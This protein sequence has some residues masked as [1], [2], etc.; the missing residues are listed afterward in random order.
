MSGLP[1]STS[2]TLGRGVPAAAPGSQVEPARESPGE[3]LALGLI[4]IWLLLATMLPG[5]IALS[6]GLI[7]ED[8]FYG[9]MVI[10]GIIS[11]MVLLPLGLHLANAAGERRREITDERLSHFASRLVELY[12]ESRLSPQVAEDPRATQAFKLYALAGEE[13]R[14]NPR[15]PGQETWGMISRGTSLAERALEQ[16]VLEQ[17]ALENRSGE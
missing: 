3:I 14:Q 13:L 15:N 4:P 8:G 9:A 11:H 2:S 5:L 12:A 1:E 10:M 6:L 7:G 16:R 17:R